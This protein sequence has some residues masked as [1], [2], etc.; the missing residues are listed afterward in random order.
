[1]AEGW[2]TQLQ[3]RLGQNSFIESALEMAEG[4]QTRM[5]IQIQTNSLKE[6]EHVITAI[7]KKTRRQEVEVLK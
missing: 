5:P 4:C 2:Q 7:L 1:M 6:L 3:I